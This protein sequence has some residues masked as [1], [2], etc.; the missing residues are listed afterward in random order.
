MVRTT[1]LRFLLTWAALF[2]CLTATGCNSMV[3]VPFNLFPEGHQLLKATETHR[4]PIAQTYDLP[5]ELA[6]QPAPPYIVEPGDVILIQPAQLDSPIRLPGDQPVLSDG[7]VDLGPYGRM[8]V[9]GKT[10]DQIA[11]EVKAIIQAHVKDP[12][13]FTVQAVTRESKVF[14]VLGEV[15]A[16][17]SYLHTGRETVLDAILMAGGLTDKGAPRK[18]ILSRPT[19]PDGQRVVLPVC[20]SEIVQLGDTTTNYQ[21]MAGDRIFVPTKNCWEEW[22]HCGDR[23]GACQK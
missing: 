10:L 12:G 3:G 21:I 16:P 8:F 18:I 19:A 5:R 11:L 22:L 13:T 23:C 15:N 6:K 4:Q 20:Y 1:A 2:G 7:T 9:A 17:G 14:Y